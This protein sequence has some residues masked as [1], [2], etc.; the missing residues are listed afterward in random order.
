MLPAGAGKGNAGRAGGLVATPA[1]A[2]L[3]PEEVGKLMAETWRERGERTYR[4]WM[5]WIRTNVR[6]GLRSLLGVL[7]IFGGLLGF[8][9][10]LGFWMIPLGVAVI[11]LD[12]RVL[13]RWRRR[14][15]NGRRPD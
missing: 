11:L 14:K 10:V 12:V 2:H 13:R 6:P 5:R 9:P 7:L 15:V 3:W 8:L 4:S 1:N